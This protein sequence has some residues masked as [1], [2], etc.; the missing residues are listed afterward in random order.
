M[1]LFRLRMKLLLA[2]KTATVALIVSTAVVLAVI[3][4]IRTFAA[5]RSALPIGLCVEDDSAE[6]RE[7]RDSISKCEALYVYESGQAELKNL[8]ADGYINC[9]FT[10]PEGY[11]G[12]I[13]SMQTEGLVDICAAADDKI[14]VLCSDIVA[15]FMIDR[16]CSV[17]AYGRYENLD[18]SK[19][20]APLDKAA[21]RAY[22][23]GL[24]KDELFE[25]TFDVTFKD[26]GSKEL[27][28]RDISNS[29]LY[30]QVIAGFI[31]LLLMLTCFTA[32]T[33]IAGECEAGVTGRL[34]TVPGQF[35]TKWIV[36][37]PV[38]IVYISP[39]PVVTALLFGIDSGLAG[40]LKLFAASILLDAFLVICFFAA[41]YLTGSVSAYQ[42]CGSTVIIVLGVMG[43]LSIFMGLLGVEIFDFTPLALYISKF[44]EL[45]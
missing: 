40:A 4:G 19:V 41:A 29:M 27:T 44:T 39:L 9:I 13:E 32:C 21:Y 43:F 45:V 16:I 23:E 22:V 34:K 36:Q 8:L 12:R 38:V 24:E 33:G 7:L 11:G 28:Y 14:A 6:A 25:F 5:E 26:A 15:G 30:M 37:I 1:S 17:R 10:I 42:I 2:D 3:L 31:G 18:K 35:I 20:S